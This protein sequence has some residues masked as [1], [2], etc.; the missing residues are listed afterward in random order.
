ME[1]VITWVEYGETVI[2]PL[3]L[4]FT[5]LMGMLMIFLPRRYAIIPMLTATLF[6]PEIQRIVVMSLDFNMI[7]ILTT[8]GW[9]RVL[10][11]REVSSL[12]LN[13]IDKLI[14]LFTLSNIIIY[15]LLWGSLDALVYRLGSSFNILGIF[16][17]FR[18]LIQDFKDINTSIISLAL[19]SI[20][21]AIALIMENMTGWNFFSI[22]GATREFTA[23]TIRAGRLR[24]KGPFGHPI[25]TG[26]F[27]ATLVPLII[28]LLF[29]K[30]NKIRIIAFVSLISAAI[31]TIIVSSSGP[32]I[33]LMG[34]LLAICLWPLRN[35]MRIVKL[36]MIILI[37]ALQLYMKAPVWAIIGRVGVVG[38]STAYHR[39]ALLDQ[40]I[41]RFDEWFLLGVKTTAHWGWGLQDVKNQDVV[42]GIGGGVWTHTLF[43]AIIDICFRTIGRCMRKIVYEN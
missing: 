33:S 37:V 28:G 18:I 32:L 31:I 12:R 19:L 36:G 17:L 8:I 27:G 35:R 29:F 41:R 10:I 7:K 22:F 2:H 39:A 40:F 5:L 26:T 9:M 38:G 1:R 20:P 43:I 30:D 25:L 23:T 21:L 14:I 42:N 6:I 16:F 4:S 24:P 34:G 15:T 13:R 3:A 11:K